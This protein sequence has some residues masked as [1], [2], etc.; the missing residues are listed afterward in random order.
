MEEIKQL[1]TKKVLS[2]VLENKDKA[3]NLLDIEKFH[4]YS[5]IKQQF[6]ETKDIRCNYLF[7]FIYRN[8][9]KLDN[10]V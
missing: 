3:F 6:N 5:F 2:T 9:Y 4:V 10:A 1:M 8:F 7:Q